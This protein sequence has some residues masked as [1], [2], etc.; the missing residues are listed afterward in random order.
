MMKVEDR[1]APENVDTRAMLP[2]P[3]NTRA[4]TSEVFMS[5]LK[6][7]TGQR[8][9]SLVVL[10]RSGYLGPKVA[11]LCQCDCGRSL[12]VRGNSL[13]TGNSTSCGKGPCHSKTEHG[14]TGT[15][16]HETWRRMKG[17]CFNPNSPDRHNYRDRGITM[18]ERWRNSFD[19]FLEDMGPRP[20]GKTSI[21]RINNDGDYEPGN[22]RWATQVEQ[23]NNMRTNRWLEYNDVLLP[24]GI[25]AERQHMSTSLLYGRLHHGWSIDRALFEP[26]ATTQHRG[27]R[28][29]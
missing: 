8:F 2:R 4:N 12:R 24:L 29:L 18:C 26:S 3:T 9:G 1:V 10:E 27:E 7:I 13:Q 25:W 14:M 21:D 20:D 11:W 16:E 17:R 23:M 15:I 6:D 22:C 5:R 28:G 19:A